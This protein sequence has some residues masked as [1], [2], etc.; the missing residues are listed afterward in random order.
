[1]STWIAFKN[2]LSAAQRD[3]IWAIVQ[4]VIAPVRAGRYLLA[5][6]IIAFVGTILAYG[7]AMALGSLIGMNLKSWWPLVFF[8]PAMLAVAIVIVRMLT[9]DSLQGHPALSL[10]GASLWKF[11]S[12]QCQGNLIEA[13]FLPAHS[14]LDRFPDCGCLPLSPTEFS[15]EFRL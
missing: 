5:V 1:M 14:L 8:V 13:Q 9:A 4:I 7:L 3:P 2:M 6:W 15:R 11:I 10:D 12:G